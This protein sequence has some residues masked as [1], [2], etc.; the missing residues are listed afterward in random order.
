MRKPLL[1][2]AAAAPAVPILPHGIDDDATTAASFDDRR[3]PLPHD[4]PE[5]VILE[6]D[7]GGV[8]DAPTPGR[9]AVANSE[10]LGAE[11][12]RGGTLA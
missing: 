9:R 8:D 10:C 7:C 12:G 2:A 5:D 4:P 1:P 6:R 11:V 3:I